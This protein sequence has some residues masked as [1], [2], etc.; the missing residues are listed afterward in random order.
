MLAPES[1]FWICLGKCAHWLLEIQ[2]SRNRLSEWGDSFYGA[3]TPPHDGADQAVDDIPW[4]RLDGKFPQ[5][6]RAL[7]QALILQGIDFNGA[8]ALVGT[9]HTD[10]VVADT[11]AG[12]EKA[13]RAVKT[14]G[15]A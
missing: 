5:Q 12:F 14:D 2:D 10:D 4:Q 7:R 15:L 11:L 9:C 13:V 3:D 6:G 1:T 8:R